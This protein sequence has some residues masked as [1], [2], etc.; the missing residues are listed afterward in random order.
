MS[1][2]PALLGLL[3]HAHLPFVRHPEHEDF[4]EERWLYEAVVEAYIPLLEVLDGLSRDGV[5][6]RLSISVSPTLAH[7]L[8]DPLILRRLGRY[9]ERLQAFLADEFEREDH[10]PAT[11]TLLRFYRDRTRRIRTEFIETHG[12]HLMSSLRRLSRTGAVELLA[13][14]ATHAFLPLLA[15]CPQAVRAQIRV[16]IA[17]HQ[18]VFGEQPAGFWLPECGYDPVLDDALTS[19]GVEWVVLDAHG[20]LAGDPSAELGV[21]AP[22]VTPGGLLVVGRDTSLCRL[23]WDAQSGYPGDPS[24]REFHRDAGF[25]FPAERIRPLLIP[26]GEPSPTGIKLHRVTGDGLAKEIYDPTAARAT[27]SAHAT[28]FLR[29]AEECTAPL[30]SAGGAPPL[31]LAAFDAE[32]FGHWWFE[33]PHWLDQTLRKAAFDHPDIR[34][35]T[36]RE[37]IAAFPVVEE[38]MPSTSSWGEGGHATT[39]LSGENDWVVPRVLSASFRMVE[40]VRSHPEARGLELRALNQALRELLLAQASDWPFL[41]ARQSAPDYAIAEV[42]THLSRFAELASGLESG[43]LAAARISALESW[44]NVFP[45]LDYR[46]Y[47]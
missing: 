35:V 22:V 9:L 2:A 31:A 45:T 8:T 36:L 4:L 11:R 24:Y 29:A 28:H 17:E 46:V 34:M 5:P 12:G 20:L 1:K 39:W 6:H 47:S 16:G 27:V 37:A 40:L 26:T 18:R 41:M 33:G 43:T 10:D 38:I 21:R 7:M 32:L 13:T 25:D 3:L 30:R 14:A 23:V 15:P 19:S 42:H 44:D